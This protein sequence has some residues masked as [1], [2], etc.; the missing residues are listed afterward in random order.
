[1]EH[2]A[3]E[4]APGQLGEEA[5]DGVDP[6]C[7][8]GRE[9]EGEALVPTKPLNDLGM[10]VCCIVVEHDVDLL[11]GRNLVL[12]DV[13]KTDELLV[14]VAL[15]T[16]AD[17]VAFEHVKGGE[18]GGGAVPFI[19]VGHGAASPFLQ[20]QAWLGSVECLDLTFLVHGQHDGMLRRI[21]VEADDISHFGGELRI[22]GQLELSYLMW[23]QAMAAPDAMHRTDADC[24]DRGDGRRRPVRDFT[25]RLAQ[26][27]RHH[28]LSDRVAERRDARRARLV[29]QQSVRARFHEALL[30][31]PYAG[32]GFARGAHDLVSSDAL[33][34][35]QHDLR[36]PY[37]LLWTIPI[38][39]YLSQTDV[40]GGAKADG[41]PG[42][43]AVDS[44]DARSTGI[45]HGTLPSG[46]IH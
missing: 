43:H 23:P 24:A 28:A 44:H 17:D 29:D 19:V 39:H 42:A 2:A 40:I 33:S 11:V 15:H 20:G 21:D 4:P 18:Q 25:R 13:Q 9:V 22:V 12:D 6:G 30:P 1:V 14:G 38:G 3:F 26:R 45:L 37:V 16:P 32:L 31:P 34:G 46:V 41:D 36:T 5:L 7:R 35:Q 10:F 27:Q 8:R